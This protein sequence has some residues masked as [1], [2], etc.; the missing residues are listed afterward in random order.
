MNTLSYLTEKFNVIGSSIKIKDLND[1]EC[2]VFESDDKNTVIATDGTAFA[3]YERVLDL[4]QLTKEEAQEVREY[5]GLGYAEAITNKD[6]FVS[7]V[8]YEVRYYS[9]NK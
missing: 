1:T 2:A 8:G 9:Y 5:I 3:F 7:G 4:N 6:M